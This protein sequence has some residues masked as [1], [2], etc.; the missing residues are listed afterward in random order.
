MPTEQQ[1][2]ATDRVP[3]REPKRCTNCGR[4]KASDQFSRN[5]TKP[6]GLNYRCKQCQRI[7]DYQHYH[8]RGGKE[9]KSTYQARPDVKARRHEADVGRREQRAAT[10]VLYRKTARGKVVISRCHARSKLR[11]ATTDEQ[12]ARLE[13]RITACNRE[14]ARMDAGP[15]TP[16]PPPRARAKYGAKSPRRGVYRRRNGTYEVKIS[17]GGRNNVCRGGTFATED[18]AVAAANDLAFRLLGVRDYAV[19][20]SESLG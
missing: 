5:R 16:S 2:L 17:T 13:A 19:P 12:R 20:R 11:R 3:D 7:Y 4:W 9:S 18:E 15:K 14:L 1:I 6:D 8:E 10:Q